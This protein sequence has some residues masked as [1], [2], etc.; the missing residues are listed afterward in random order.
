MKIA[1]DCGWLL[2]WVNVGGDKEIT[3]LRDEM[4]SGD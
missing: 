3:R 4:Q 2:M 1:S